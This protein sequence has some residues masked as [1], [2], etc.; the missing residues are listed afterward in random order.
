MIRHLLLASAA[1]CPRRSPA[2]AAPHKAATDR[3]GDAPRVQPVRASRARCRSR[4]PI[5]RGS[6]TAIICRRCSPAWRSRRSEVTAIANDPAPPTFD[7]TVVA[8]ERSGLLLERANLRSTR[9]TAPTPTIR[10]RRPIPRPRRCSPRTTTSSTSMRSCSPRFKYLHDHQA[11]PEPQP[12]AGQAAR[13]LLQA[14][15]P[16]RRRAAARQAGAAQGDQHSGSARFRPQFTQKLLAAAKAGALHVD[17]PAALAGLSHATARRGAGSRQG[18]QGL[19]LRPAA[20][21]H[22]AAAGARIR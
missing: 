16:C 8:M 19:R 15:R 9:S 11:E 3:L 22:D 17:D 21:E 7:N 18:A 13:R 1:C 10:C 2:A 12:R 4:R 14:V 5:S 20:A 6:R